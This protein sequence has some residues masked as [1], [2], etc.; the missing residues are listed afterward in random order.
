MNKEVV[1]LTTNK[2]TL[3]I[4][5]FTKRE[6]NQEI[7]GIIGG[8]N[9][10]EVRRKGAWG[11]RDGNADGETGTPFH[12]A[13]ARSGVRGRRPQARRGRDNAAWDSR[14]ERSSRGRCP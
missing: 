5:Y 6:E 7:D 1:D 10:T 11:G 12:A 4:E 9:G 14:R 13:D 8:G 3:H 2:D